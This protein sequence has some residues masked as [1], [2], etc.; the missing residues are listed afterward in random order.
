MK[1]LHDLVQAGKVRYVG[2]S[3][4]R[5]WQF[6]RMNHV[7]EKNGWTTFVSMQSEYSL[8]YR[9]EEREMNPYCNFEG[10]GLIPWAPL[11]A[12]KLARPA[13]VQTQ[14]GEALT[15]LG[16][17]EGETENEIVRR[18]AE[19]AEKRGWTMA[20]VAMAWSTSKVTSPIV[21]IS[22]VERLEEAILG[23]RVLTEE[24]SKY[25]EEPYVPKPVRGH[26]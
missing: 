3:S 15:A 18:V 13:G 11:A 8:L 21:G 24:E 25:L 5:A 26:P 22:S 6:A 9:E 16:L 4:M 17:H 10:V 2:A 1:A 19:V 23:D 14:R 20:Q 12:G 7:A